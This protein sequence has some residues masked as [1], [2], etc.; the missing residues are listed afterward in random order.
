VQELLKKFVPAADEVNVIL[1]QRGKAEADLFRKIG[2]QGHYG[3]PWQ[4]LYA[5]TPG[6]TLLGSTN[7]R[8]ARVVAEMLKKALEKWDAMD[9]RERLLETAPAKEA[10]NRSLYPEDGLV[11]HVACRDLPRNGADVEGFWAGAWNEDFAWFTREEA[12][13]MV[14]ASSEPGARHAVPEKLIRRLARCHLIDTVRGEAHLFP[15]E[16]VEKA[17]LSLTV[18]RVEGDRV[19][20]K[21]E[22][23]VRAVQKGDWKVSASES[24]SERGVDLKLLGRAVWDAKAGRFTAFDLLAA[25]PRWGGTG[26]ARTGDLAPQPLGVAFRLAGNS[27]AERV[28]PAFVL[29]P[30]GPKYFE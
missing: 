24:C 12:K 11:L 7:Q 21:A 14:P 4:G 29:H 15:A 16:A 20:L 1:W 2:E 23:A 10:G 26:L 19:H 27:E 28:P 8:D 17:G 5:A 6:G 18:L 25:G 3:K 22:G 13:S 9:R 30:L